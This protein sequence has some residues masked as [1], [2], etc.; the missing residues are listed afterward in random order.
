M[1]NAIK[2]VDQ[3]LAV[4]NSDLDIG[5]E[6]CKNEDAPRKIGSRDMTTRN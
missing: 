6:Y 2:C 5:L 1:S 3:R 4:K